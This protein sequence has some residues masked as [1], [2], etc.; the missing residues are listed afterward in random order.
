MTA[1]Q[2]PLNRETYNLKFS[3]SGSENIRMSQLWKQWAEMITEREQMAVF[4]LPSTL[5]ARCWIPMENMSSS[6]QA[7]P[8]SRTCTGMRQMASPYWRSGRGLT[9]G[10]PISAQ[11]EMS[12][13]LFE[14]FPELQEEVSDVKVLAS[15]I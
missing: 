7:L 12:K 14:E 10:T 3:I 4:S 6:K 13:T 2:R 11:V 8:T 1:V 15:R 9:L 5:T